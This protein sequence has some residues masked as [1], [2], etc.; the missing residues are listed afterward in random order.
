M[1]KKNTKPEV[2]ETLRTNLTEELGLIGRLEAAIVQKRAWNDYDG[3]GRLILELL[4]TRRRK[5]EPWYLPTSRPKTVVLPLGEKGVVKLR[6]CTRYISHERLVD[7]RRMY[8]AHIR[9]EERF[10]SREWVPSPADFAK[11]QDKE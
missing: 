5:I 8:E 2:E 7:A 11:L 9:L 4:R 10:N 1:S 3:E 6:E